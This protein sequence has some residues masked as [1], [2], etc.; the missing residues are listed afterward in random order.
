MR[1]ANHQIIFAALLFC[2]T[3]NAEEFIRLMRLPTPRIVSAAEAYP[4]GR[5]AATAL[6]DSNLKTEFASNNQG[7]NTFV[8]FEFAEPT[9]ITACRYADRDDPATIA[10]YEL[11]F[12]DGDGHENA[13]IAVPVV[14]RR[15]GVS[16]FALAEPV[17]ARRVRWRV[18]RL[19]SNLATVG[20]AEI[21]FWTKGESEPAPRHIVMDAKMKDIVTEKGEQ[22]LRVTLDYPYS[23]PVDAT[24]RVE[25]RDPKPV[26][27]ALGTQSLDF[28][29]PS[30]E[31]ERTIKISVERL[32]E[33]LSQRDVLLKPARHMTVYILPHS[34]TDIGYTELQTEIEDKQVNNLLLG[35]KCARDTAGYPPGAR[36]VWNVEVLWAADLYLRRLDA[37]QRDEFL[38]AVQHGQVA[39]NGMYLNE[40][41]GLCR[42][43]E[44]I[45][46]FRF[47][48]QLR[49]QTGVAIDS[50]MISD[51]PGYTWGTVPAMAQA[52][53]KYFSAAPNY[54]DRIGDILVQ[55]EN[56]PFWW[57]GPDGRSRVLVWI[58]YRGYALS[59]M[60]HTLTPQFVEQYQA[61]LENAGYSYDI[62]YMRWSGHGDNATPDP[63]ICEFV[64][65]W[66]AKNLWPK[67]IIAST[68]EAFA[69]FERR[70]GD[71][72]PQTRG[73]WTPYWE[74]GAGSSALETGMNRTSSDRLT[75]AEA[76]WAM[77]SSG[78]YP[79][80]DFRNA[81]INVLLYSEHTWGAWCSIT[82]PARRETREQ[83][84]IKQSYAV[85][86]DRDSRRLLSR[87]LIREQR[88]ADD[89]AI[90]VFN[91]TSWPR[92]ELVTVPK[93]LAQDRNTITDAGGRPLP[94]QRLSNGE[95]VCMP[96]GIAPLAAQ[97]LLI[98]Q[99]GT[100]QIPAGD[101]ATASG[102]LLEN[103]KLR[104]RVDERTGVITELRATGIDVNLADT[105]SAHRLNEYLYL[106][107]DNVTQLQ[108]SG[109][110]TIHVGEKGPLVASLVIESEAPG[111]Y[112]LTRELRLNAGADFLEIINIVDKKRIEAK[113]Y[114]AKEGK[115]SVNFAFPFNVPNGQVLLDVPFGV[116]RPDEDQIASA[117]RNWFTV[118]R[119]AEVA[120]DSLGVTWVTLDA[121]LVEVGGITANL[122]N[123]QTNPE[124]WRKQVGR[125]QKLYSW[126]MNNHWGTNYRAYQEGPTIFRFILRPHRGPANPAEATRFATG[127]SQPLL[128]TG[129]RGRTSGAG[130][131]FRVSPEDVLVSGLKPSDEGRAIIVRLFNASNREQ[132]VTLNWTR[133]PRS[134]R[135]S[136]TSEQAGERVQQPFSMP[137][138]GVVALRVDQN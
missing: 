33:I 122:L 48:T 100:L 37:R 88:A 11:L 119:W 104:V 132:S 21:S 47:A 60:I 90:D 86:A 76:L 19:G 14:N 13:R 79:A 66:S 125:T 97:R 91:T 78:D 93:Y 110:A 121:P 35:M 124:V 20:G 134:I 67:F 103:S 65:N 80:A 102:P 73:D 4:D 128:V 32:G 40:L 45:R 81:W 56:K 52:G 101:A 10:E 28:D 112:K 83:W 96:P 92:N 2:A 130:S 115:E 77:Q 53:I 22:S 72:L 108:R 59:H 70:Y 26:K 61:E 49:E 95:L 46:L 16:F 131:V 51:V 87:A 113:D 31:A 137:A 12:V 30:A 39:L 1:N 58:P 123:S 120:N 99:K 64:K 114:K 9:T 71:K 24:I 38:K 133:K 44:L 116:V 6:L 17:T 82:E 68:S 117:C 18:S 43:S 94:S 136:D 41:T 54:F 55:W 135:F 50:A 106:I 3:A 129:A 111:C 27:L 7:T 127:F 5:H 98:G 57:I 74:D 107:G 118:G 34:H 15:A 8:E 36:F 42:P 138:F 25:G 105:E 84:E 109:P 85:T 62:T 63:A 126:A 69:A 29:L 75:Q 89:S 23:T